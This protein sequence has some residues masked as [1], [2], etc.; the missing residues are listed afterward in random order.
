MRQRA[1]VVNEALEAAGQSLERAEI[2]AALAF[3]REALELD[4]KSAKAQAIEAA[5]M[6]R[7]DEE[8]GA[9]TDFESSS[10][11]LSG[12]PIPRPSGNAIAAAGVAVTIIAAA[13]RR[14]PPPLASQKK[15]AAQ[16][17]RLAAGELLVAPL[18]AFVKS[19]RAVVVARPKGKAD[20]RLDRGSG[21]PPYCGRCT[22]HPYFASGASDGHDDDRRGSLANVAG[23]EAADGTWPVLPSMASTPLSL[24][25]PLGPIGSA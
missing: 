23:I 5:A 6:H 24:N 18:L 20:H 4:P 19:I 8:T 22:S 13:A 1:N 9:Q 11:V 16:A 3:A 17:I 12:T 7:L 14:T 2:E 21:P 10:T 25:P 15:M